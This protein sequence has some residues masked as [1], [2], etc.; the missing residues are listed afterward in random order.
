MG[1]PNKNLYQLEMLKRKLQESK[2][3][4]NRMIEGLE[5]ETGKHFHEIKS[6]LREIKEK[7]QTLENAIKD[8]NFINTYKDMEDRIGY[9]TN[10]ISKKN[11]LKSKKNTKKIGLYPR[12]LCCKC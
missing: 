8:Y 10:K 5:K 12:K 4:Q 11:Y 3:I 2:K 9:L 7:I 6:E 1:L